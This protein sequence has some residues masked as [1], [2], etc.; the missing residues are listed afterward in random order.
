MGSGLLM[1]AG[2]VASLG[3]G[4]IEVAIDLANNAYSS[5]DEDGFSVTGALNFLS[6]GAVT[7]TGDIF[8][9]NESG[10]FV[11]D[12]TGTGNG[13]GFYIR[14]THTAG[15]NQRSGGITLNVWYELTTTRTL[16]F[17][18]ASAGGPDTSNGTYLLEVGTDGSTA[19][20]SQSFTVA[21]TEQSP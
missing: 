15:T 20:A 18:K 7:Y 12:P 6:T 8:G 13:T 21:L 1:P 14:I 10:Q 9:S 4:S 16:N 19:D 3:G 17:S 11:I 2:T 5:T